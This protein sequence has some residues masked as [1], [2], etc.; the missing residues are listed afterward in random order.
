LEKTPAA[1]FAKMDRDA[2][3]IITQAEYVAA[4]KERLGED[5]A[6]TRFAE[7]DKN[8]DGKLTR[9]EFGGTTN[10]PAAKGG[11]RER[12]NKKNAN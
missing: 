4:Q 5:G 7:L 6:K 9:E 2:N 10:E 1:I 12:K 8:H 3:G 11:K